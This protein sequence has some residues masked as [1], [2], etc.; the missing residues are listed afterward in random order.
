MLP[1]YLLRPPPLLVPSILCVKQIFPRKSLLKFP[2]SHH[3][4]RLVLGTLGEYV[5]TEL[6]LSWH[7]SSNQLEVTY[8][9][10]QNPLFLVLQLS[11]IK[12]KWYKMFKNTYW[13]ELLTRTIQISLLPPMSLIQYLFPFWPR[14]K[15]LSWVFCNHMF[16]LRVLCGFL[17]I[18]LLE[19]T[20]LQMI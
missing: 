11:R 3:K 8:Y 2:P 6:I 7:L 13:F 10:D 5:S 1:S 18:Q 17:T 16:D 20:R 9:V 19:C 14:L 12:G 15:Q 4:N